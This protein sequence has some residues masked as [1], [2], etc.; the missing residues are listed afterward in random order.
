MFKTIVL[1]LD[2]SDGAKR[3]IPP[4]VE[5]AKRDD[6]KI[7]IA[8]VE[9]D[10]AGKGGGPIRYDEE[11]VQDEIKAEAERLSE[12]GIDASVRMKSVF[13]GGPAPAIM[14]IADSEDA[15]L[16]VVGTR[17]LSMLAGLAL[18]GVAQRLL[19][20]AHQPVLVV[21]ELGRGESGATDS[22]RAAATA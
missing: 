18:G 15:D 22:G 12:E 10:I 1:A 5:L 3:A 20:L 19:H 7:V 13:L 8:H 17:G 16:I 4:A 9:E 21:P 14:E 11:A 2:G 6:A